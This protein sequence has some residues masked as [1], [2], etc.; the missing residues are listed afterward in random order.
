[1]QLK[2]QVCDITP[3]ETANNAVCAKLFCTLLPAVETKLLTSTKATTQII[4]PFT[5]L[6]NPPGVAVHSAGNVYV[7]DSGSNRVLKL[8][9]A[10]TGH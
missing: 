9:S 1:M 10:F 6:K 3:F 7:I 8:G 2:R 5:G 4:L